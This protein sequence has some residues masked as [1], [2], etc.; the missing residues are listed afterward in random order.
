MMMWLMYINAEQAANEAL[1]L[2][3]KEFAGLQ[4]V[5]GEGVMD[6]ILSLVDIASTAT[7]AAIIVIVVCVVW[8]VEVVGQGGGPHRAKGLEAVH[9]EGPSARN[10]LVK[11]D[12]CGEPICCRAVDMLSHVHLW[13]LVLHS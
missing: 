12:T 13:S 11:S 7:A 9:F 2:L 1:A 8:K 3:R 10:K 5:E 4:V 6:V